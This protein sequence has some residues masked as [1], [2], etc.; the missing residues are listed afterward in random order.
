MPG[1]TPSPDSFRSRGFTLL[2]VLLTVVLL[3][4]GVIALSQGFSTGMLA[5]TEVENVDLALNI[6]QAKMETVKDTAFA[7]IASSGP[8]ADPNFSNFNVTVNVTG[9]DPKT[10]GVTVAWNVQG[11]STRVILTTLMANY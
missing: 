10:V 11:G 4:L 7:G 1:P 3:T 9:A 8:T 5:S 6:A 2:E